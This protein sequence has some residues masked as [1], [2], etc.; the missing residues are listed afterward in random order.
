MEAAVSRTPR[1]SL[2]EVFLTAAGG[3]PGPADPQGRIVAEALGY[4]QEG[5][6]AH[7][8]A[9]E[10]ATDDE[11]LVGDHAY[12]QAVET[13]ARLDEPRFVAVAARMIRDGAGEISRGAT[14]SVNLW[15]PHLYQLLDIISGEGEELSRARVEKAIEEVE[16]GVG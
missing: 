4:L 14:V 12:A 3:L 16:H 10:A 15:T 13:I 8:A 5:F 2:Q 11:I 9:R 7:Y 6:G 1:V